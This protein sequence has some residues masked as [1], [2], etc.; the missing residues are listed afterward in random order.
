MCRHNPS[1]MTSSK[2]TYPK[3]SAWM[4]TTHNVYVGRCDVPISILCD[5]S[6]YSSSF[7]NLTLDA[8]YMAVNCSFLVLFFLGSLNMFFFNEQLSQVFY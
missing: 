3:T 4:I 2:T 7:F 6:T 8:P 5:K 1:G